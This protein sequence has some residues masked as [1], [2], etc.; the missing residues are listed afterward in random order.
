MYINSNLKL[1]LL[2]FKLKHILCGRGDSRT[3]THKVYHLVV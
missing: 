1:N 3:E 2:D